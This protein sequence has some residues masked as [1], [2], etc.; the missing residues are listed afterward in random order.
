MVWRWTV[1]NN[2][3]NN[4][5]NNKLQLGCH[6]VAVVILHV[7]KYEIGLLLNLYWEGCMRSMQWQ[8]GILGTILDTEK[9][10]KIS[11]E[12]AGRRTFQILTSSQQSGN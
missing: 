4:N 11:V 2:N 1:K 7:Y 12:V 9:P 6:L 5:N 8:L 10:R 3:N